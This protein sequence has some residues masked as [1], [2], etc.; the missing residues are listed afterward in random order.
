MQASLLITNFSQISSEGTESSH[1]EVSILYLHFKSDVVM[2]AQAPGET[3]DRSAQAD[4]T[5]GRVKV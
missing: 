1:E 5:E 4:I 3:F 2:E